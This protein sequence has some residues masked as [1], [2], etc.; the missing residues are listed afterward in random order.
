MPDQDPVVET[1]MVL[2]SSLPYYRD[3]VM[4][5]YTKVNQ[6]PTSLHIGIKTA[7]E[8]LLE[9]SRSVSNILDTGKTHIE[10]VHNQLLDEENLLARVGVIGGAGLVGLVVGSFRGRRLTRLGYTLLG[11]GAGAVVCY[12]HLG[13]KV[14]RAGK[15]GVAMVGQL[16]TGGKFEPVSVSV[17]VFDPVVVLDT[18]KRSVQTLSSKCLELYRVTVAAMQR[19]GETESGRSSLV[20][21]QSSGEVKTVDDGREA[22][23]PKKETAVLFVSP[24]S[25]V[26]P[27]PV[28]GDPGMSSEEDRDL[29]TTRG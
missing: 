9:M 12:P 4:P 21:E 20:S 13:E 26:A 6:E 5:T 19:P 7:R 1:N 10:G 16:V 3:T 23:K 11:G 25:L 15:E 8:T 22:T 17:P 18:I 28:Q 24:S 2:P 14:G 27:G 29:Y